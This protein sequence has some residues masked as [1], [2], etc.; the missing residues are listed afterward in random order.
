MGAGAYDEMAAAGANVLMRALLALLVLALGLTA[1]GSQ[2]AAEAPP[3]DVLAVAASKTTDAGTYKAE[4]VSSIEAAG[5]SMEM[6]GTG[7]FDSDAQRGRASY[8]AS[9][10]GQDFDLDAV[11]AFPDMYMRFPVGLLPGLPVGKSWVKL[12]LEKLGRQ[13]GFDFGQLMQ[14]GQSDPSQGLQFLRG[15]T[16]IQ[17]VGEEDVRGVPTT[18]YTGV[19]DLES[20]AK[21]DPSLKG[22]IDQLVAQTGLGR[23]PVEVWVDDENFV[24]RMKQSF[25]GATFGPGMQLDMTMTTELYDFGA[26]VNVEVPAPD[27]VVELSELVGNPA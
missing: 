10:A 1:C 25:E 27:E 22:S 20:L 7:E 24:S 23:I 13:A 12:N 19:V 26:D 4:I 17:A 18:H 6:T 14:A 3:Q 16:N 2:T 11:F 5:Q 15:M 8:T 21:K 9:V